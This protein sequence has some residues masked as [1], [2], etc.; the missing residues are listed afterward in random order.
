MIEKTVQIMSEDLARVMDRRKF[1]KRAGQ[2]AFL[3]LAALAAGHELPSRAG[4]GG[5]PPPNIHCNPPGPYCSVN[6]QP[7]DG[8]HGASCFQHL[9]GGQVLQC[10]LYYSVW[11]YGCYTIHETKGYWTCC[12]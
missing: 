2:A 9:Y 7:A 1:L 4:A 8:C 10:R 11:P 5:K 6:G 12:D 3:G